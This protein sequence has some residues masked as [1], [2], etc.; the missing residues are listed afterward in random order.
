MTALDYAAYVLAAWCVSGY[1]ALFLTG[2][3]DGVYI[4]NSFGHDKI[5]DEWDKRGGAPRIEGD[6]NHYSM[7]HNGFY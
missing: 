4:T 7:E 2:I 5:H 1:V 3:A 6:M